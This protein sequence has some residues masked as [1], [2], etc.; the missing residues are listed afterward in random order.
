MMHAPLRAALE[1]GLGER[2]VGQSALG[3]GD[4]NEAFQVQLQSGRLVFVKCNAAADPMMFPAEARG[5][6]WLEQGSALRVPK[7]LA[8]EA[9]ASWL[10]RPVGHRSSRRDGNERTLL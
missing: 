8:D 7:V 6:R 9:G 3:G 2:V 10:V 1:D 5:L 4:I